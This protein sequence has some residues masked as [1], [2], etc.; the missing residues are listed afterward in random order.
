M[1]ARTASNMGRSW[2]RPLRMTERTAA[3]TSAL[4]GP[5]AVGDRAE[6]RARPHRPLEGA[7]YSRLLAPSHEHQQAVPDH[8]LACAPPAPVRYPRLQHRDGRSPCDDERVPLGLGE[9]TEIWTR[10]IH[11]PLATDAG[12]V[13]S[14]DQCLVPWL[15]SL[16]GA[17]LVGNDPG[18]ALATLARATVVGPGDRTG[19]E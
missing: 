10:L 14:M 3:N 4:C 18:V 5:D 6:D 12:P 8:A 2:R 11:A 7:V 16:S 17:P 1:A 9:P 15:G 19:A 13:V